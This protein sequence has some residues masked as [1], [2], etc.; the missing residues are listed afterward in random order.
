MR[1]LLVQRESNLTSKI[2]PA[3]IAE[4]FEIDSTTNGKTAMWYVHEG[5]HAL[6]ILDAQLE[7]INEINLCRY[8]R[9]NNI[10][11]PILMIT[12]NGTDE[13]ECK[14]LDNGADDVI[15]HPFSSSVMLARVQALLRRRH[16]EI[17]GNNASFGLF[18]LRSKERKCFFD[19]QEISLTNREYQIFQLLILAEG[20]IVPKQTIIDQIWGIEFDGNP[21]IVDVYIGYLRK[22]LGGHNNSS[23]LLQTI[24]GIGYRLLKKE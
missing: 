7:Q 15:H 23:S 4:G 1:I 24:R 9:R 11:I 16:R 6:I 22:K 19:K 12:R 3:L 21:N 10:P 18:R 17:R 5:E 8:I 2:G 20:D 14:A 13:E